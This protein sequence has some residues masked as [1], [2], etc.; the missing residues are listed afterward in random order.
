MLRE[1]LSI[2]IIF[3]HVLH[4]MFIMMKTKLQKEEKA[5]LSKFWF[6]NLKF[7]ETIIYNF[8]L[9]TEIQKLINFEHKRQNTW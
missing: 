1:K 2:D 6:M 7:Q 8:K 4:D 3:L 5:M 9:N